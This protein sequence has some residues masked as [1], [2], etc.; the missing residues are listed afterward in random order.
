MP[1]AKF[2]EKCGNDSDFEVRHF[3]DTESH[4]LQATL[5]WEERTDDAWY[6]EVR[7][8][9]ERFNHKFLYG[10]MNQGQGSGDLYALFHCNFSTIECYTTLF[11]GSANEKAEFNVTLN[12][13][14][15]KNCTFRSI[16]N[17]S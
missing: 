10:M 13:G 2:T 5:S 17:K 3:A 15:D 4:V 9:V 1:F 8:D 14:Q 6:W 7:S 16:N 12:N 11:I